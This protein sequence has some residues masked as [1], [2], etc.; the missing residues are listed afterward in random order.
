MGYKTSL[1]LYLIG[2]SQLILKSYLDWKDSIKTEN[3]KS[4]INYK[5][6]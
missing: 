4:Y 6:Q 2:I 1:K 3:N 5:M